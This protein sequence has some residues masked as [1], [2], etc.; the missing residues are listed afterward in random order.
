MSKDVVVVFRLEGLNNVLSFRAE[1]HL[2][3]YM[4]DLL[5]Q[6]LKDIK[7]YEQ[8]MKPKVC[9]KECCDIIKNCRETCHCTI[10][11]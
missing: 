3:L 10:V 1:C 2:Y 8:Q 4:V 6:E 11:C 9:L 5:E 7:D